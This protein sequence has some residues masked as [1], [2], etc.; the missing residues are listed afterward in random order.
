MGTSA[1]HAGPGDPSEPSDTDP[2]PGQVLVEPPINLHASENPVV[3]LPHQNSRKI[4][5]LWTTQPIS[6]LM[7]EIQVDNGQPMPQG[8]DKGVPGTYDWNVEYGH[9]YHV[10]VCRWQVDEDCPPI[11]ITTVRKEF[12]IPTPVTPPVPYPGNDRKPVLDNKPDAPQ[13]VQQKPPLRRV[14]AGSES[15]PVR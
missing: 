3:F 13:R 2:P 14:P 6:E 12:D 1:A 7:L 11:E 5:F 8:F 9:V 15:S 10:W 4:Q